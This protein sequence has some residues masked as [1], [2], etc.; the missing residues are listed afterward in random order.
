[1]PLS[2]LNEEQYKAATTEAGSNLIIASAGTGK[3]STIVAR[4]AYLLKEQNVKP[5]HILL[6]TFTN[7]AAAEML[8]RVATYFDKSIVDKIES[9]T[10]H[11]VSYRLLKKLGRKISLKQPKDLKILLKTIHDRRRFDHID[12]PIKAYQSSYLYDLFSLYQNS[13]VD[14]S[15]SQWLEEDESEHGVYFDIYEDI[16]EEFKELK[17]EY[18]YVDFNDLLILMRDILKTDDTIKFAEVLVDEYQD[19]NTLQGSLIDTFNKK[20]LFC[21]GDYDQSIYA[22]NGANIDIIGSFATRYNNAKIF[23]LNK[24]YRSTSKILSL[25]NRVIEHNPRLYEKKLE[26]TRMGECEAPRLLI[27]N[28][29]FTQY[30]SISSQIKLSNTNFNDIAVIFRNNS[31]AD[32]IEATLREV[33]IT[34]KR[35]GGIS[36]FDSREVKAMMDLVSVVV[37]P[38]DMM[39]FIHVF[40]YAKGVGSALS[41]EFFE[42]LFKLGDGDIYQGFFHPKDIANPFKTRVKNYQLG[43]FDDCHE[44][45]SVS[46]FSKEG[47]DEVFLSNPILKHA[48]LS[49]EGSKFIYSF[50]KYMKNSTRIKNPQT[51]VNHILSSEI[52]NAIADSLAIARSTRKDGSVDEVAKKEA[53]ARIF[54]K[55]HLLK[56]LANGYKSSE[57]FLNALTLGSSEMSE[58]E[59]VNLLS[60]HA[61]KG[62]E[63]SEVYVIDLMDGR[64]P[65][66]KLMSKGGS[67]EEERRLFYVA[68]TR[69]KDKL[70]L[71]FAK[72]DKIKKIEYIHSPFLKEAKL[73]T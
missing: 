68:T 64:F 15:F 8:E 36:F 24:N 32:G 22:F 72:F 34:C 46:R 38:K 73:V 26:V 39:A 16:F 25:A 62:L 67:L 20:S 52:F 69:A 4:I 54:R 14:L 43:L 56:D 28:E 51:L 41:K 63:F 17:K 58:G 42:A 70:A 5:E 18:G 27:Y 21:V 47:F 19:T 13:T 57:R 45:G 12:S 7:K 35:K 11:A 10:F 1:M 2:R 29:L 71:S 9:G 49:V 30:Q 40:E 3:T 53:R 23:K 66:R 48:R 44:F 50:Y 60:V 6:L 55:G 31:S 33:G 61:S 37:N 59:G 65:N